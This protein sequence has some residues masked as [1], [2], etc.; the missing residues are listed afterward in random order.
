MRA[1]LAILCSLVAGSAFAQAVVDREPKGVRDANKFMDQT[2]ARQDLDK[3]A[4]AMLA[5][6]FR[7]VIA[8]YH[9]GGASDL[10][11]TW[12]EFVTASGT[13]FVALQL[14]L[15]PDS[16]LRAAKEYTFFGVVASDDGKELAT[17][18]ETIPVHQS[19]G[20]LL[21]ERSLIVPVQKFHGIFGLANRGE[22][23]GIAR[24]D[25]DPETIRK[26]EAGI[27]RIIAS[28]DVH[29]MPSAQSPVE[30][31]AFGGTKV[32]PKPHHAFRAADE[33]WLFTELRNPKLGD[34]GAPHV[35]TKVE[36]DGPKK[37]PGHVIPAEASPLKGVP[38]HYGIGNTI[39]VSQLVPG[40]YT[41]HVTV[42]DTVAKQAFKRDAMLRIVE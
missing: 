2:R 4:A 26:D 13:E 27:S 1:T 20:D 19:K 41:L 33:V 37:L 16:G 25:F 23:L 14:A 7:Q 3:A 28:S 6:K 5:P 42:I 22:I 10:T 32:V 24:V 15:P 8:A 34:D 17:Y 12:A 21:V 9:P 29:L 30:P 11:A 38:G 18:S 40:D 35:A 39:D 36:V 31:F